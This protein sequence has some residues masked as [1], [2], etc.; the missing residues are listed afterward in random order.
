MQVGLELCPDVGIGRTDDQVPEGMLVPHL[1]RHAGGVAEMLLGVGLHD[2][3][4]VAAPVALAAN[5]EVPGHGLEQLGPLGQLS[6]LEHKHAGALAIGQQ[7]AHGLVLAQQHLQLAHGRDVIDHHA[8]VDRHRQL[9]DLPEPVGR[10]REDRQPAD[11]GPVDAATDV[12]LDAAQVTK[13][14]RLPVGPGPSILEQDVDLVLEVTLAG[15]PAPVDVEV[16][17]C[18]RCSLPLD[19]CQLANRGFGHGR[20]GASSS[21]GGWA[22]GRRR[23]PIVRDRPGRRWRPSRVGGTLSAPGSTPRSRDRDA[24]D[25]RFRNRSGVALA[26]VPGVVIDVMFSRGGGGA[27]TSGFSHR[28]QRAR[29]RGDRRGVVDHVLSHIEQGARGMDQ[30]PRRRLQV[31]DPLAGTVRAV[32]IG[33]HRQSLSAQRASAAAN[34]TSSRPS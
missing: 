4:Q 33:F 18:D 31:L 16:T 25:R 7:D 15:H 28:A 27:V 14:G 22:I 30:L 32:R 26:A 11:A 17:G 1:E 20:H 5:A 19:R 34:V 23:V 21:M 13:Y 3:L 9:D 24:L 10:A 2:L 29:Q 8:A 12:L 6:E